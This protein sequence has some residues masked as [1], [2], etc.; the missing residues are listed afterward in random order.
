M[1]DATPHVLIAYDGSDPATEAI[2]VAARLFGRGTRATVLYAWELMAAMPTPDGQAHEEARAQE[3]AQ[4]G[5]RQARALG[6]GAQAR[7]EMST[8]SAWRTIVDVAERDGADL[9][10]MGTRG[11]S[12]VRSLLLGG[13][14]HHVAQHARSP[15]LIVP[16]PEIA[17]ARRAVAK[18]NGRASFDGAAPQRE[19]A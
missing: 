15:V 3:V 17:D 1:P 8:S 11:R 4:E 19:H 13:I 18:A 10:V 14:S 5:A 6:L 7:A 16:D 2:A 12:G 9:V